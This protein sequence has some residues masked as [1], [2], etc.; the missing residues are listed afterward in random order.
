MIIFRK[1]SFWI[2][3]FGVAAAALL[4]VRLRA[5]LN[6]PVP[7][8]PV[9]P[10]PK[11]FARSIGAAGIVEALSENTLIGTPAP[12]LVAQVH[13]KVWDRVEIGAPLFTIDSRDLQ[14]ALPPQAAQIKVAEATVQRLR[15]QLSRLE[16]VTDTRAI[17]TEDLKMRRSD[18]AVALAQ[19]ESSRATLAQ[20]QALIERLTVR[21]PIAGTVI[22]LNTRAGEYLTPSAQTAPLV[23][24]VIDQ[25][26]VR[27]DV[28]EQ[29][30]PRVRQGARA[31]ACIKGDASHPI[32]LEFV[33]IEPYITPKKSLTGASIERVDTR[34]L[35]VIFSFA[36][37]GNNR[38]YVGQQMDIYIEE[39]P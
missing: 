19:V 2:A 6:E 4:I 10:T 17:S 34:V 21:A 14:A 26:Q 5:S 3:L 39:T 15:D 8:P 27:A 20:T 7:P 25:L 30:A 37:P 32:P 9:S 35:Q 23:L 11:P 13:V 29:L 16:A 24:G 38:V 33:R 28:D 22:Q 36:N 31:S 18:V 1:I 12:G